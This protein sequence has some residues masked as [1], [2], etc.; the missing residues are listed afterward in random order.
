MEARPLRNA[1]NSNFAKGSFIFQFQI[2]VV[3][4][5][6][7]KETQ[8]ESKEGNVDYHNFKACKGMQEWKI[9]YEVGPR[10]I[11]TVSK[12]DNHCFKQVP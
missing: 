8:E 4:L 10:K 6:C 7:L 11:D 5:I 9:N 1:S 2:Q 12:M 3:I